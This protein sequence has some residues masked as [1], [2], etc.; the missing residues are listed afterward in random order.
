MS[1]TAVAVAVI[2]T[3]ILL[4][5]L[6]NDHPDHSSRASRLLLEVRQGR[7]T[8][9]CPDTAIFEAVYILTGLASTPRTI[10]ADSLSR[11]IEVPGIEMTHKEAILSALQFWVEQPALDFADCYH[12][13]LT[14]ALGLDAI[15]TFD[16]RMDRFPVVARLEP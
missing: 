15:Y 10:A 12:L 5:H 16:R 14:K 7:K 1:S 2:D 6:L 3:N 8:V 13:A 11:V 9:Y 4:R